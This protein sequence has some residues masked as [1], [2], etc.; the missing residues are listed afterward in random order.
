MDWIKHKILTPR[1]SAVV[2][3][4]LIVLPLIS[5]VL[6]LVSDA[7]DVYKVTNSAATTKRTSWHDHDL[8]WPLYLAGVLFVILCLL[9]FVL[10][11]RKAFDH[12][13]RWL[14]KIIRPLLWGGL[15][16]TGAAGS[17]LAIVAMLDV[18]SFDV[19]MTSSFGIYFSCCGLFVAFHGIYLDKMPILDLASFLEQLTRDLE[20]CTN[21]VFFCYP[22][23]SIGSVSVG[24]ALYEAYHNA[25]EALF[26]SK[27]RKL[28]WTFL[29]YPKGEIVGLYKEYLRHIHR[30]LWAHLGPATPEDKRRDLALAL[31]IA[32]AKNDAAKIEE[33]CKPREDGENGVSTQE[34]QRAKARTRAIHRAITQSL[35]L[36]V[37][38]DKD[39]KK[40]EGREDVGKCE[41]RFVSPSFRSYAI[42]VDDVTYM[43]NPIGLPIK[44]DA[45]QDGY[46]SS[47][48]PGED[49]VVDW[50]ATRIQNA[51][52][53]KMMQD[54][55]S[56]EA[57][58]F[59]AQIPEGTE[60]VELGYALERLDT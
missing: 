20:S 56:G 5:F 49:L 47:V 25:V 35:E 57:A 45:A 40:A 59:P 52:I 28:N 30:R 1:G 41:L 14:Q 32:I 55:L 46:T 9:V 3:I 4:V 6:C 54:L 44:T 11:P 16:G 39:A 12:L 43:V 7:F 17:Y 13:A 8:E 2:F 33:L 53:A 37:D 29:V 58:A 18:S 15:V 23:L 36:L 60:A 38:A 24:G 34:I 51:A 31:E 21:T 50:I 22:G 26:S 48:P 42:I 10:R 19:I 27:K